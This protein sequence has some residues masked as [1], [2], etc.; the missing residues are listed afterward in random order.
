MLWRLGDMPSADFTTRPNA[1]TEQ[2]RMGLWR[3]YRTIPLCVKGM[4]LG[5]SGALKLGP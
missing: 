3:G 4:F 2:R 1:R 5:C